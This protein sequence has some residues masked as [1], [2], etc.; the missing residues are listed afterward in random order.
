[1]SDSAKLLAY[2]KSKEAF[3]TKNQGSALLMRGFC[4]ATG[5]DVA[6]NFPLVSSHL[7]FSLSP[8]T[9]DTLVSDD[10]VV[11][12]MT[13]FPI[14]R[15]TSNYPFRLASEKHTKDL[16]TPHMDSGIASRITSID[17]CL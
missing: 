6:T 7:D 8:K 1:M 11:L 17:F 4:S 16:S 5:E 3:L 13:N 2:E 12:E 14:V 15:K 10:C 9:S